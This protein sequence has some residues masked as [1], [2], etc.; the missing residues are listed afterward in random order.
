MKTL[1]A[2][3]IM[4]W[5]LSS[6][7]ENLRL[8][9]SKIS[10]PGTLDRA[11]SA[12]SGSYPSG[13]WIE[14]GSIG[15]GVSRELRWTE[16]SRDLFNV[17]KVF[18]S[19]SFVMHLHILTCYIQC[20]HFNIKYKDTFIHQKWTLC[21][22]WFISFLRYIIFVYIS[23]YFEPF[24]VFSPFMILFSESECWHHVR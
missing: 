3:L 13:T 4:G 7:A 24:Y 9:G 10:W 5:G 14:S 8:R 21:C 2:F 17:F 16:R 1:R 19:N 22:Y 6:S 12:G 18:T 23:N 11:R 20:I 15:L